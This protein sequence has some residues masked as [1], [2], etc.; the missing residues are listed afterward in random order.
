MNKSMIFRKLFIVATFTLFTLSSTKVSA[1]ASEIWPSQH[2]DGAST[3]IID[4]GK[5]REYRIYVWRENG[6]V[7][8]EINLLGENAWFFQPYYQIIQNDSQFSIY[9]R[10]EENKSYGSGWKIVDI[11]VRLK[12]ND[13]DESL[14]LS[15]SFSLVYIAGNSNIVIDIPAASDNDSDGETVEDDD[16]TEGSDV[17]NNIFDITGDWTTTTS[18]HW[19]NQGNSG[20]CIAE[21]NRSY[22]TTINQTGDSVIIN[23]NGQR[24]SGN[25]SGATCSVSTSYPEDGGTT[26][27]SAII[28]FD[29]D[30]LGAGEVEWRWSDGYY[31]CSGGFD[32]KLTKN[33]SENDD[34]SD[35]TDNSGG[36]GGGC[37]INSLKY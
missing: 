15:N 1:N 16:S 26:V 37:F 2:P 35:S 22:A 4:E 6:E 24:Y 33:S 21:R 8:L 11:I 18:N 23:G 32:V 17:D 7:F 28:E 30:S 20:G 29:S 14:D 36:G 5:D 3:R 13:K 9:F 34:Q 10:D 19:V 31:H 25:M 12:K 27:E